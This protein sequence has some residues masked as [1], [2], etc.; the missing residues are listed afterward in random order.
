MLDDEIREKLENIVRGII[1]EEQADTCTAIRNYLCSSF[2]TSTTVR[3]DF[4]SKSITKEEQ[5]KFLRK[6]SSINNY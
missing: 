4:E 5:V 2:S 1:I 6:L 3:K